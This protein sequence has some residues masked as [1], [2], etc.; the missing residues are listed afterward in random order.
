MIRDCDVIY[1]EISDTSNRVPVIVYVL[2]HK[3]MNYDTNF[4]FTDHRYIEKTS[5]Q[6]VCSQLIGL[7]CAVF[8]VS[9]NTV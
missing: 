7:D 1:V 2:R 4:Q 5:S 8:Y 3:I 9:S 6:L